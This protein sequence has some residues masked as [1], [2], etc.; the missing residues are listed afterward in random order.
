[1]LFFVIVYLIICC[2]GLGILTNLLLFLVKSSADTCSLGYLLIVIVSVECFKYNLTFDSGSSFIIP[3]VILQGIPLWVLW[4]C[5]VGMKCS[6]T[7]H[8]LAYRLLLLLKGGLWP[9]ERII[10]S[11]LVDFGLLHQHVE[12]SELLS[13]LGVLHPLLLFPTPI[14]V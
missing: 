9:R 1:M 3:V 13:I 10:T 8:P 6:H 7:G 4:G 2:G 11:P 5:L 12:K 14:L